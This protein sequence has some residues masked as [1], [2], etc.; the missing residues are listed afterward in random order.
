MTK[1]VPLVLNPH[2]IEPTSLK[3]YSKS[4]G[5]GFILIITNNKIDIIKLENNVKDNVY[6]SIEN[7]CTFPMVII[8]HH[9]FLDL[10]IY[11]NL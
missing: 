5:A 2:R 3:L 9:L 8:I 6:I 10:Q 4:S 11:Y 7:V 1:I